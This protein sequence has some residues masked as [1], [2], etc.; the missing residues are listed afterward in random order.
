MDRIANEMASFEGR[1]QD[2]ANALRKLEENFNAL[3]THMRELNNMWTGEAHDEFLK[4]FADDEKTVQSVIQ[5]MRI[6]SNNLNYAD[7]QYTT[8]ENTVSNIID[9]IVV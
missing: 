8:C 6:L 1:K 5:Y 2:F 3:A 9:Q 7:I 4:T